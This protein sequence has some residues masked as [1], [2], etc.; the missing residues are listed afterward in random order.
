MM[1]SRSGPWSVVRCQWSVVF[2][3]LSVVLVAFEGKSLGSRL[4]VFFRGSSF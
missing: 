1:E 4:F 3:Q 2:N